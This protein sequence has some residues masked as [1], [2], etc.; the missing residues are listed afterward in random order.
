MQIEG[1][2]GKF[3]LDNEKETHHVVI[4]N[5]SKGIT[6][7]GTNL[8]ILIFAIMIACLG[9]NTNSTA[10]IIG[11]MLISPLMGPIMGLG[12]GLAINDL[13]LLKKAGYNYLLA[14]SISLVSSVL[15]FT[16]T[17]LDEAHSEI[18]AR[19]A[20]NIYDVLIAFFGG[21]SGILATSSKQKGNVIPGVAIATALMP[22]LCTAGYGLAT[23]QFSFF[24]GAFYLYLINSVFIAIATL[25]TLRFLRFPNKMESDAFAQRR[26]TRIVWLLV[27]VLLI[28]SIYLG[29]DLVQQSR[30]NQSASRFIEHEA[31][32]QHDYLLEKKI[33]PKKKSIT[34]VYG[35]AKIPQEEIERIQSRLAIYGLADVELEIRQGFEFLSAAN[36]NI[37]AETTPLKNALAASTQAL[38]S[39]QLVIDSLATKKLENVQLYKEALA[40]WPNIRSLSLTSPIDSNKIKIVDQGKVVFIKFSKAPRFAEQQQMKKW[41]QTKLASSVEVVT[42]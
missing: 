42:Y 36:V 26:A 30:F 20:P 2:L 13:E 17:P 15:Y 6:F 31:I 9:L 10:V 8:W 21:L 24:V 40:L 34:L 4:Q 39:L 28:P 12:M 41:F 38:D 16:L 11:A 37:N 23:L 7:K 32:I 22:P 35:G 29:Y 14:T 33:D 27:L 5:I 3:H 19:T 18:L 25:I 1:I